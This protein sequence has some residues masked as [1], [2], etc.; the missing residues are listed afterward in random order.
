MRGLSLLH[1]FSF[2][3][4]TTP[5]CFVV[6]SDTVRHGFIFSLYRKYPKCLPEC[7]SV[8][9]WSFEL[10]F[11]RDPRST[12]CKN[13]PEQDSL[14]FSRFGIQHEHWEISIQYPL[15]IQKHGIGG[16]SSLTSLPHSMGFATHDS[17]AG[18]SCQ[19][20]TCHCLHGIFV[21]TRKAGR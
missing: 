9:L 8:F 2:L 5:T 1:L 21:C 10:S 17:R 20:Y 18:F 6:S 13:W 3:I 19:L 14:S 4:L 15:W 12:S 16:K 11:G 7:Y